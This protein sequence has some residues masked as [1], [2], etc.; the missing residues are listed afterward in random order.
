MENV[1]SRI[2]IVFL[3]FLCVCRTRYL[4]GVSVRCLDPAANG[5]ASHGGAQQDPAMDIR[6]A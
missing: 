6:A 4:F 3:A 5:Y 2:F 1:S